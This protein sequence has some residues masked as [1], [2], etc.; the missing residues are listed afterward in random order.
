MIPKP[1]TYRP[2]TD[3]EFNN[4]QKKPKTDRTE[5][6]VVA[7]NF[8]GPIDN[9]FTC[10]S[11]VKPTLESVQPI[12]VT[13]YIKENNWAS[14]I[15]KTYSQSVGR[16]EDENGDSLGTSFLVHPQLVLVSKHAV[17]EKSISD[18]KL[19]FGDSKEPI[20]CTACLEDGAEMANADYLLLKLERRINTEILEK[21]NAQ[22]FGNIV[23][24]HYPDS[25]GPTQ[26]LSIGQTRTSEYEQLEACY[27]TLTWH[28]S[29]GSPLINNEGK[30]IG[31]HTAY[32]K[33]GLRRG[34][35][36][37]SLPSSSL[38]AHINSETDI[39]LLSSVNMSNTLPPLR[40]DEI[41]ESNKGKKAKKQISKRN[42]QELLEVA[43]ISTKTLNK[44]GKKTLHQEP[45]LRLDNEITSEDSSYYN[46]Q[47][48][49]E[50]DTLSTVLVE[51]ML[52]NKA[53]EME[54]LASEASNEFVTDYEHKMEQAFIESF[55]LTKS[56]SKGKC[57]VKYYVFLSDAQEI[58]I[59]ANPKP[60]NSF[61]KNGI[62]DDP[63][64]DHF[65]SMTAMWNSLK[66]SKLPN[67]SSVKKR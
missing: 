62:S 39:N 22:P 50:G 46:L 8:F 29:S 40:D 64:E 38:L 3:A 28:C 45:L 20:A 59:S 47:I 13:D 24:L 17:M 5:K 34:E 32:E 54:L 25:S 4:L 44:P 49:F 66:K 7:A 52:H 37:S 15:A 42:I 60:S 18:L 33:E 51:D 21:E 65:P 61:T 9:P 10:V 14:D 36:F 55:T 11:P 26:Q 6:P 12:P 56:K 43:K 27:T 67:T 57:Y 19:Y 58:N 41:L 35:L 23:S 63:S 31:F 1:Y 2:F 16:I 53:I 48:Q 30:V